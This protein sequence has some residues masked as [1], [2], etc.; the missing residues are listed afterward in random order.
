M[1]FGI[2][3]FT[4]KI[5]CCVHF[6]KSSNVD[7][8]WGSLWFSFLLLHYAKCWSELEKQG[9]KSMLWWHWLAKIF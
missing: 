3:L 8:S 1:W 6:I 2:Y 9:Q 4:F 5:L 7:L